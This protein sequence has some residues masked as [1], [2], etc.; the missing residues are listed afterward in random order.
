MKLRNAPEG[1]LTVYG[2][3]EFEYRYGRLPE[4]FK[5]DKVYIDNRSE[6]GSVDP[7]EHDATLNQLVPQGIRFGACTAADLRLAA[8]IIGMQVRQHQAEAEF[9]AMLI[10]AVERKFGRRADLE[11]LVGDV[12]EAVADQWRRERHGEPPMR[13][14]DEIEVF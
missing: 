11:G 14:K 12:W 1:K 8:E 7:D 10:E 4:S 13:H 6:L 5:G 9:G 2:R 3:E